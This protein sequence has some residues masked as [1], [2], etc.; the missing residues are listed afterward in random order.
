MFLPITACF[1]IRLELTVGQWRNFGSGCPRVKMDRV[2]TSGVEG[3]RSHGGGPGG[4]SGDGGRIFT[5]Y[6]VGGVILCPFLPQ[7]VNKNSLS[8]DVLP[9]N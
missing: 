1:Y 8:G 3:L 6:I 7:F 5:Q 9:Q 4:G 2:P